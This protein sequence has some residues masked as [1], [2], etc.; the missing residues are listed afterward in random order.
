MKCTKCGAKIPKKSE[1]CLKC[2]SAVVRHEPKKVQNS[3]VRDRKKRKSNVF[4]LTGFITGIIALIAVTV[5]IC[6]FAFGG[7]K[8]T[9]NNSQTVE[10]TTNDDLKQKI[11]GRWYIV[12][13]IDNYGTDYAET[14]YYLSDDFEYIDFKEDNIAWVGE[15][16]VDY[17]DDADVLM[18]NYTVEGD[19]LT[20]VNV[21]EDESYSY[22]VVFDGNK[23]LIVADNGVWI[24]VRN[25]DDIKEEREQYIKKIRNQ[26]VGDWEITGYKCTSSESAIT[27]SFKESDVEESKKDSE[28]VNEIVF[29]QDG[30]FYIDVYIDGFVNVR[31]EEGW[32]EIDYLGIFRLYNESGDLQKFR[33]EISDDGNLYIHPIVE[34]GTFKPYTEDRSLIDYVLSRK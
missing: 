30:T 7:N 9:Y 31:R 17:G 3:I 32:F 21:D 29:N 16:T 1:F 10:I 12:G 34:N 13:E 28:E 23:M 15:Y 5:L 2:G 4:F 26:I 22:T 24:H 27:Y 25:L 8:N 33:L 6:Y 20:L 11:L 19:V 18:F 14:R